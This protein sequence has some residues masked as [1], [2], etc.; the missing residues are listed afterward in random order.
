MGEDYFELL[1][2]HRPLHCEVCEGHMQYEAGGRYLCKDCGH[3]MFDDY[4]KIKNFLEA[5]RDR[6]VL[7]SERSTI[8]LL[9]KSGKLSLPDSGQYFLK[10][11]VCGREIRSGRI[12]MHCAQ[13][14]SD[15]IYATFREDVGDFPRKGPSL[16]DLSGAKKETEKK[17]FSSGKARFMASH[18]NKRI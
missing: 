4:G 12:C 6:R 8:D 18:R 5:H 3:I 13:K 15:S 11:E 17:A 10:C 16:G 1:E 14:S 9:L 2:L 7:I